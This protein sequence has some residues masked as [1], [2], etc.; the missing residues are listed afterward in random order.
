M[1]ARDLTQGPVAGSLFRLTAP[2]MMGVSSNILVSMLEIGFIGQLG[3]GQVAAVTFT[4][5]LVMILNSVALGIGIGTSSVIARNV[6]SGERDEVQRLGTHSLMLVAISMAALSFLGWAT[7]DPVFTALGATPE[8]MPLIHSY[9][10][11]YYP[12]VILF[13]TTMVAGNIMRANGSATIP[14]VVMT[15]GAVLHLALDPI[16]IF[17]LFGLP[18]LELAGAAGAMAISRIVTASVLLI[19]VARGGMLLLHDV[20]QGFLGSCRRILHVGLPAMATQLI[21]PVSAAV[22]T[23]LLASHGEVVVAGFGVATR[24]EAVAVML[25]F[26]LS[27]SIGPFVGQNWGARRPERV[28][29]GLRVTYRFC[30]VWGLIAALPLLLFGGTIASWVDET[31]GVV[32][33][34]AFYLAVVPWSYGLWGVLMMSSASFNALGKPLPSTMLSFTRMFILYVPL[35]LL[36][37]QFLGYTGIFVA[38]ALS[39]GVMGVLGFLWFRRSFFPRGG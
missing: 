1:S 23:R 21:G 10:D 14:G 36:L 29:D 30:L 28:R 2:M 4:F 20:A 11:I 18:R 32:A 8:V 34:A 24:V 9:L 27:G 5:P 3:T 16:L 12:S 37:N 31:E 13:T 7:I 19:Y 35:A 22:I 15:L 6:G 38:T 17:G 25:L 39:N 26:A 33:T